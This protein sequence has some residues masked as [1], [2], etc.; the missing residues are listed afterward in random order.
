M[1]KSINR[2]GF[3]LIESLVMLVLIAG[4]TVVLLSLLRKDQFGVD[5]S[6]PIETPLHRMLDFGGDEDD[7]GVTI[8]GLP[9]AIEGQPS[10]DTT[11]WQGELNAPRET[12]ASEGSSPIIPPSQEE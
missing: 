12:P 2:L 9:P 4:V 1:Q 8:E 7:T 5:T 3:T 6:E 11:P 10:T